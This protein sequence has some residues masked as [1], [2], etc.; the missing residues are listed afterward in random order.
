LV[1]LCGTVDLVLL[2][3]GL[4]VV[5]AAEAGLAAADP[6]RGVGVE[7]ALKSA[8]SHRVVFVLLTGAIALAIGGAQSTHLHVVV[9]AAANGSPLAQGAVAT[10]T[11]VLLTSLPAIPF[12]WS[13]L[14][15]VDGSPL[16]V[17]V[18]KAGGAMVVSAVLLARTAMS[19]AEARGQVPSELSTLFS[20]GVVLTLVLPAVFALDQRRIRRLVGY[21]VVGQ[22]GLVLVGIVGILESHPTAMIHLATA[23]LAAVVATVGGLAGLTFWESPDERDRTWEDLSGAGR[24]APFTALIWVGLLATLSGM[25]GTIGLL[26]R[27]EMGRMMILENHL[28]IFVMVVGAPVLAAVPVL[29]LGAFLFAKKV[30]APLSPLGSAWRYAVV[31]GAMG[32]ALLGGLFPHLLKVG[33]GF[34]GGGP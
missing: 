34:L 11:V 10:L 13:H 21:L 29:R 5:K 6:R 31:I 2:A 18:F 26:A 32:I 24:A 14:D 1:L 17:G 27:I 4:T 19:F 15:G 33:S 7:A 30:E 12:H 23:L 25:P 3:A 8:V 28:I 9:Q 16:F 22:G 20:L